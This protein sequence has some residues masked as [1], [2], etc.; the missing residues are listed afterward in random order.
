MQTTT[1]TSKGQV[2]IPASIRRLLGLKPGDQVTFVVE[3]GHVTLARKENRIEA[4]FGLYKTESSVSIEDMEKAIRE[5]AG[6]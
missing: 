5:R 1:L 3:D 4:A 6:Q 2:T